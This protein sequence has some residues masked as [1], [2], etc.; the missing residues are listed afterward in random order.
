MAKI[1]SLEVE[2]I[3]RIKAVQLEPAANG[4]TIIGGNNRQGKTSVLDALAWGLGGDKFRPSSPMREGS[5]ANP[6][7]RIVLDNGIIV[8]R[9]GKN[10]SLKVVDPNGNKAGQQLLN[11]FVEQLALNL[12]K[13]MEASDK[14]KADTLLRIIGVGDELYKLEHEEQSAYNQRHTIGQIADQKAKYAKEMPVYPD[15][16]A[17]PVSASALIQQ[18]QEILA[19]NGERQRWALER[20]SILAK[21]MKLEDEIETAEKQ[22]HGMR[23]QLS[24]LKKQEVESQKSPN[25]MKM[26]STAEIEKSIAEIEQINAKVRANCDR[27]KAEID[28]EE[29]RKQYDELTGKIEQIREKKRS[30]LNGAQMPLEGLSVEHGALVYN[31]QA[32]DNMSGADQMIVAT[33]IVRKLNPNCGFVLLDKLEQMDGV[34][35]ASFAAWLENE[36]LQAIATRVSTGDECSIIIEDGYSHAVDAAP[37]AWEPGKF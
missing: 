10:S 35:L 14:E 29:Y 8:E 36:G 30:L 4:L 15:V 23:E 31:G 26:E 9:S 11:S 21:I 20:D 24:E 12:P 6:H 13:F 5:C 1:N 25:Q 37:K 16:P 22:I 33:S 27:E 32:W 34:T 19:R 28:A 3:K 17:E 7:L 2:N 18:Q